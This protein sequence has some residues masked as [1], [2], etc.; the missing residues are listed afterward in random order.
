MRPKAQL[1]AADTSKQSKAQHGGH[2]AALDETAGTRRNS[3]TALIY[4]PSLRNSSIRA[5][6]QPQLPPR[7]DTTNR[8]GSSK[9][10]RQQHSF[11][12]YAIAAPTQQL[13]AIDE[14]QNDAVCREPQPARHDAARAATVTI[15]DGDALKKQIAQYVATIAKDL[16]TKTGS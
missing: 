15:A 16:A 11:Q 14:T 9:E 6:L 4:T 13:Y 8:R 1:A 3:T 7:C 5:P 10:T 2:T 12:L